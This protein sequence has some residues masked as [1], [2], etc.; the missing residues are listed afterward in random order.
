MADELATDPAYIEA[1]RVASWAERPAAETSRHWDA[2]ARRFN[3]PDGWP[4]GMD[5]ESYVRG[6]IADAAP[7]SASEAAPRRGSGPPSPSVRRLREMLR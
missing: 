1:C 2:G 5:A 3:F 4:E 6:Q 7:R